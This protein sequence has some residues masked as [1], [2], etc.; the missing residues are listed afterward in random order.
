MVTELAPVILMTSADYPDDDKDEDK[1]GKDG[2][3][4]DAV[5]IMP[6]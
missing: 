6:V 3:G 1:N 2:D 5:M 4:N